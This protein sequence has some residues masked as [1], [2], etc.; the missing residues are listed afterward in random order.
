MAAYL[1]QDEGS[2]GIKFKGLDGQ[3]KDIVIPDEMTEAEF[4]TFLDDLDC[5]LDALTLGLPIEPGTAHWLD[6]M[7]DQMYEQLVTAGLVKSRKDAT[8]D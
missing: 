8:S 5:L 2:L 1:H 3:R 7:P 6:N 4:C